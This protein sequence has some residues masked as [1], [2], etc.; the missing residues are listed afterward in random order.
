MKKILLT[1]GIVGV[2]ITTLPLVSA[3]EAHIVNV[4]AEIANTLTVPIKEINFGTVFPQEKFDQSFNLSMSES[5]LVAEEY[6][7]IEYIL[8]QKPKC[9]LLENLLNDPENILP[10]FG[11]VTENENG[12]FV[13]KDETNYDILPSLSLSF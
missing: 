3:F 13:C 10:E 9:R 12:D 6:D 2:L 11:Q 7:D 8:R 5:F 1:V 4:T